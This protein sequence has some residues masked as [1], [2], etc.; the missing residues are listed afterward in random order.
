MSPKSNGTVKKPKRE[1]EQDLANKVKNQPSEIKQKI[2]IRELDKRYTYANPKRGTCTIDSC[3]KKA[4]HWLTRQNADYCQ[5]DMI[6][7]QHAIL[8]MDIKELI[9]QSSPT[10]Y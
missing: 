5:S 1:L 4:T 7:H 10:A 9:S 6:C 8:W 2:E 3:D